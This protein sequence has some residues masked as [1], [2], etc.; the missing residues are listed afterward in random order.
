M[1]NLYSNS[2]FWIE[3]DKVKPNPY[4]P[5]RD[6]DEMRLQDLA[7][8][9]KQYG[10]LQPLVVTRKEIEREDGSLFTEYELIAG[11]R[12]WR[13]SQIAGLA[14]VP[15]VIRSGEQ[16]DR[17]KLELA[18]IENLQREDLN[19]IER[20][21]AFLRL[22][23]G[24][25]MSHSEVA[26]KVGRSREFVSNT[27]R[28]LNLP[29]DIL[30]GLMSGSI[31]EGHT[32]PLLMLTD[33]PEQQMT[34]YKEI[35]LKNLSVRD[36]EAIARRIAYDRVRRH[37]TLVS[38]IIMEV[39][40]RLSEKFGN[41]VKVEKKEKGGRIVIDWLSEEDL[42]KILGIMEKAPFE[43]SPV[44]NDFAGSISFGSNNDSGNPDATQ[45]SADASSVE[46][47]AESSKNENN[48]EDDLYFIKNFSV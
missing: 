46:P 7:D 39:E 22:I 4:Q 6:F 18:I 32:R 28:M 11:E 17:E 44:I 25:N 47:P 43:Q 31:T 48:K 5:R 21:Q 42:A 14:R 35:T 34:V 40:E 1:S 19:A 30:E 20:A 10:V 16:S 15:A 27:V 23:K 38:P 12:R 2:I 3:T 45:A 41:R 37:E 9:I 36:A 13:A 26:K 24:F 29:P 8:S 33:R